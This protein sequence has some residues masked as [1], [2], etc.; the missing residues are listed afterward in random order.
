MKHMLLKRQLARHAK[1]GHIKTCNHSDIEGHALK[2]AVFRGDAD[3]DADET[4]G[5]K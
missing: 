2:E 5:A 4:P 1:L 3:A